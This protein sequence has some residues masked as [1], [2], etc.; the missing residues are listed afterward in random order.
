MRHRQCALLCLALLAACAP[1]ERAVELVP[2]QRAEAHLDLDHDAGALFY[3]DVDE[4][5]TGLL[6]ATEG[7]TEDVELY[8]RRGE[9]PDLAQ[10]AYDAGSASSWID[11]D[12]LIEVTDGLSPGRWYVRAVLSPLAWYQEDV[13]ARLSVVAKLL[14]PPVVELPLDQPL[15]AVLRRDSGLRAVFHV[16]LPAGTP[17][18]GELRLEVFSP[19]ADVDLLVGSSPDARAW[20]EPLAAARTLR[21]FERVRVDLGELSAAGG[22][23]YLQAYAY[24]SDESFVELP[25]QVLAGSALDGELTLAPEPALPPVLPADPTARAIVATIS[26]AG[27]LGGGSGVVVSPDGWVLTNA[28]VV[29]AAKGHTDELPALA[30][31]FTLDP[32]RPPVH[33]FGLEL[34]E[35]RE[36]LDLALARIATTVDGRPLPPGLVFPSLPLGPNRLPLGTPLV[37]VGYPMTG[38][39][40]SMISVTLT[41]GVLSGYSAEPEGVIYKTDA[42]VHAGVSGGACIDHEGR[43]VGLPVAS[44]ADAN[45]AGGLGFVIPVDRIPEEWRARIGR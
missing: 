7:A 2:G 5:A 40:G 39:S 19:F 12:L 11:E 26:I 24:P 10:D 23:L 17:R 42:A 8:A 3:V 33:T 28:H 6:I 15:G 4:R 45:A 37:V 44:I 13:E 35:A 29:V 9:P 31:G 27:P 1:R 38:G 16:E 41:Q 43:L 34:V 22:E 14:V 36:D 32:V 25:I 30:A 21:T 18:A 20:R